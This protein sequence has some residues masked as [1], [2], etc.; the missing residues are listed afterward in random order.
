M[1]EIDA[2]HAQE[3]IGHGHDE[4]VGQ[5]EAL[6]GQTQGQEMQEGQEVR[7][8]KAEVAK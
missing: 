2:N 1:K 6:Q 4:P 3:G 8:K 5:D 7:D